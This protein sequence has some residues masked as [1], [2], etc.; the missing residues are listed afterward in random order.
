MGKAYADVD[1]LPP[2]QHR[3]CGEEGGGVGEGCRPRILI[4]GLNGPT[5]VET[6]QGESRADICYLD[7]K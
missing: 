4:S 5:K 7:F 2:Y 6:K 1:R 3:R